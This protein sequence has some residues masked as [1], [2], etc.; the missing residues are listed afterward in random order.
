MTH[1]TVRHCPSLV[2]LFLVWRDNVA[3]VVLAFT[4]I[5]LND[6]NVHDKKG[7]NVLFQTKN[8]KLVKL[9]SRR[10][11]LDNSCKVLCARRR[12]EERGRGRGLKGKRRE[13]KKESAKWVWG[14]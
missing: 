7:C 11:Q 2:L 1:T 13:K 3:D 12:R 5:Q 9:M 8:T 6:G 14:D 10:G 4:F